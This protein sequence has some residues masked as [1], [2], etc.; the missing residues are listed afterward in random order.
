MNKPKKVVG[1]CRVST[2]NQKEEGTI[3]IQEKSLK[4]YADKN[5]CELVLV[6]IFKDNGISGASEL[7]N[8]PELAKL[9]SYAEENKEIEGV[10]IFKLDRLARD[11]YIQEHL[12]KKLK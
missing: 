3:E 1:Y 4:I 5:G 7:E 9:F 10:L 11:I 12:I 2:D 8:R 6:N